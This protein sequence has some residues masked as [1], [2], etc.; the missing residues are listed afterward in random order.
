MKE[1]IHK[2]LLKE[3]QKYKVKHIR[4]SDKQYTLYIVPELCD[5]DLNIFE[6]FLFVEVDNK[7]EVSYL[8]TRY[9]PPVSGYAPRIGIILYNGHLLLKDYRKNKYI[10][11]TLKKIN[12]TFLNKLK[13]ALSDPKEENLNK[14]FDRSD[15]IEEFYIL[16]KRARKYLLKNIKGIPEEE[17]REEFIDNFMMQMLTLWYLQERGFFNNDKNYFITKF[18]EFKQKKL[19]GGFKNYYEF[20][21]YFFEKLS[22]NLDSQYYEDKIVG[23]VVVT[24]PA[25]FLNGE[26]SKAISIPDKCFYKEG[27]TDILI[28]TPPK[29]VS[30]EVLLLNLFESRDWTEGNIDEFV[31]GAIYEK[32]ITYM[33]RKKLGAYYTPEE[34]TSYI[35]KNTIEPYL[36][37]RVNEKFKKKFETIDQIVE[38]NDKEILLYLF[39]QLKEIK[40]LD[41]AA[42][43]AHFL[44]SA[45]NVLVSIYEKIREKAIELGI[46]KGLEIIASDEKGEIKT[47]NLLEISDDDKFK[48]LIK[49]FIILSKNIYGVDINPSALK[50]AKARLFLTLAKHFKVGK[51]KDIFIRF[52]NVHFNLRDGNSL[53]GYVDIKRQKPK[54][55]LQLDFFIE[56]EQSEYITEKIKV[57]SELKPYLEKTAKSLN[58][59]GNIVEEVKELNKILAKRKID[60]N[61]FEKVLRT[62]EKLITILIASLNSKYAKPLNDLLK[63]ITDLFNQK[64]DEKFAEEHNIDLNKLKDAKFTPWERK[65]FHWVFEF[66]EV[67]MRKDSGFDIVIGNPPYG[68]LKQIIED[69]E[70]KYFFSNIYSNLYQHQFGNLNLYKLFI[71]RSYSLLQERGYFSMIF[72]SSFLGEN[73]S[74]ELRKLFFEE[75]KVDKILEFPEKTRVFEGNTQAVCVLFYKKSRTDDYTVQIKTNIS[76]EEKG[77]LT[78]L[79][80]LAVKRSDLKKLTGEDYRIPLFYNPKVEWEI[81][82]HISKYPPFKGDGKI[83]PVGEVGEGHLHE[84][85]DKEFMSDELGDDLLIKGIHLDRYFV[86]LDPDGP[87]PRWIVNKEYFFEK[88]PEAKKVA[89]QEKVIGRNTI[90]KASKPRLRFAPLGKGYVITNAVKFII[91]IDES[92]DSYFLISLLNSTLLNWRFEL[93][94]LQNNIRNYEIESLPIPRIPKEEQKPFIILAKYMLFL[95][96]YQNYFAREDKHFQY[97]IDY[98]DNLIDC[99]VYELYLGD[100][101]KIPTRQF[102]EGKLADI[103]LPENLLE[104]EEKERKEDLQKIEKVFNEFENDK[105]LNGNLYLIK[106]HPWVKTIYEALGRQK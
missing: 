54:E 49:F 4:I 65:M 60:W 27:M 72:P 38:S 102:V 61:D 17:K 13:K 76:R 2:F 47:I 67:F 6:G 1:Q 96:Q 45:I 48:L 79:D 12:K 97:I 36:V 64:L 43:S 62:K 8:K 26:H 42:G 57:I 35:C 58:L 81:L 31:L 56:E 106:L 75:C 32:L 88:K 10:I 93:F 11:K 20:L 71:E 99:L 69:K 68:R 37:D 7:S 19:F 94:S 90:N 30:Q 91:D 59:N 24:G 86:N 25:I 29:K 22:N 63:K 84:T 18:K 28:N 34:I 23:R 80:F 16:Y 21:T 39:E 51:E 87:K 83:P 85:F 33:E 40:I 101:V 104:T 53:I 82:K 46:K 74:K 14:L 77:N 55:Q 100:V 89:E 66:P 92:I 105:K 98:F 15:V 52:P 78:S 9:K 73:D 70:E 103:N 50:V 3:L 44:E 5:E 95:K 41:P